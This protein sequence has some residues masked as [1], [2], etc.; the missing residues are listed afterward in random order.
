MLNFTINPDLWNTMVGTLWAKSVPAEAYFIVPKSFNEHMY[1]RV[2]T[3]LR[4][5]DPASLSFT[6]YEV[7]SNVPFPEAVPGAPYLTTAWRVRVVTPDEAPEPAVDPPAPLAPPP[8]LK[9]GNVAVGTRFRLTGSMLIFTR[10]PDLP[11]TPSVYID[12]KVCYPNGLLFPHIVVTSKHDD[13][14]RID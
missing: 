14:I 10:I 2:F 3:G 1:N 7:G 9:A 13:V 6:Y 4:K 8:S 12:V 11:E 5:E